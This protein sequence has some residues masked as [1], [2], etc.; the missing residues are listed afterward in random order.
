M[1]VFRPFPTT[2]AAEAAVLG[3]LPATVLLILQELFVVE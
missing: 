3:A 1:F 2:V